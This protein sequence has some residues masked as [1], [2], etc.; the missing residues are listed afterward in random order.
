MSSNSHNS[1]ED[2]QVARTF[3]LGCIAHF[4]RECW[5]LLGWS[6]V[7]SPGCK[8]GW[9]WL[10]Q[11]TC[12][13]NHSPTPELVHKEAGSRRQEEIRFLVDCDLQPQLQSR[14]SAWELLRKSPVLLLVISIHQAVCQTLRVET[15]R[16]RSCSFRAHNLVGMMGKWTDSFHS[17]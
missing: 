14:L 12:L 7:L 15:R 11:S 5:V 1:S 6:C 4:R 10:P 13:D 8:R 16:S 17:A 9:R 3:G 2:L